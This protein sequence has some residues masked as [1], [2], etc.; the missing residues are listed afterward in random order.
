MLLGITQFFGCGLPVGQPRP[1]NFL[2]Q[3]ANALVLGTTQI[4]HLW[5]KE[6]P[7]VTHRGNVAGIHDALVG[8]ATELKRRTDLDDD[9]L[10][11]VL[12]ESRPLAP[13]LRQVI[14]LGGHDR[15]PG[16]GHN[17]SLR[18]TARAY[19]LAALAFAEECV[20][21]AR[22]TSP[23]NS[24]LGTEARHRPGPDVPAE[25]RHAQA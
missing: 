20:V 12:N 7:T 23:G 14:A 16:A 4:S 15:L 8:L 25:G 2:H 11:D 24:D 3:N 5:A 18:W 9:R 1:T 21:H 6:L 13:I 10:D 19:H 22:L 17:I